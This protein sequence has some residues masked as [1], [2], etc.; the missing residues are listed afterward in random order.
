MSKTGIAVVVVVVI[1]LVVVVILIIVFSSNS[2]PLIPLDPPPLKGVKRL[3]GGV[4][5]KVQNPK[6]QVKSTGCKGCGSAGQIGSASSEASVSDT[7]AD[8]AP[9]SNASTTMKVVNSMESGVYELKDDGTKV[10]VYNG[11]VTDVC[12]FSTAVVYITGPMELTVIDGATTRKVT[13]DK[14]VTAITEF[15]GYLHCLSEGYL[16]RLRQETYDKD[17]WKWDY[18]KD[19]PGNISHFSSTLG[20]ESFLWIQSGGTGHLYAKNMKA[21]AL[22]QMGDSI[23]TY[24]MTKDNYVT[25]TKD[26]VATISDGTV[27]KEV[28]RAALNHN[29]EIIIIRSQEAD[30]YTGIRI[31]QWK[32]YLPAK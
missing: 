9:I 30:I 22:I 16:Y 17:E 32:T 21:V 15:A 14:V 27:I 26:G 7:F 31:V 19:T 18:V 29:N 12:S 23:R 24:G 6:N 2:S 25:I 1:A 11:A 13:T 8:P 5:P 4:I 28:G 10:K 3:K 20:P